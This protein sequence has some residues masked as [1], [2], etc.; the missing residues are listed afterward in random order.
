MKEFDQIDAAVSHNMTLAVLA[1]II[2]ALE[3]SGVVSPWTITEQLSL[4]RGEK[5]DEA[6]RVG[7]ELA[8]EWVWKEFTQHASPE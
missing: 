8:Q 6:R 7:L 5:L 2:K 3:S 1:G 4:I